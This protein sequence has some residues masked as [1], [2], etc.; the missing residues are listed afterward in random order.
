MASWLEMSDL[1]ALVQSA[2]A[3]PPS[4]DALHRCVEA[5]AGALEREVALEGKPP[6]VTYR[7]HK[8]AF[9]NVSVHAQEYRVF[10][11]HSVAQLEFTLDRTEHLAWR[12][13]GYRCSPAEM[14]AARQRALRDG[15]TGAILP[16]EYFVLPKKRRT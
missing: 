10:Y 2:D 14:R 11:L 1:E 13:C 8:G 5:I 16:D 7:N 3:N 15:F 9:Y 12:I 4:L 6:V